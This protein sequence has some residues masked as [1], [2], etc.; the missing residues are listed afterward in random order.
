MMIVIDLNQ[1]LLPV[2]PFP[3]GRN[4][5][6]G[7]GVEVRSIGAWEIMQRVKPYAKSQSHR[8]HGGLKE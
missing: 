4:D 1:E 8:L 5:I 6:V 2:N 7:K 3:I